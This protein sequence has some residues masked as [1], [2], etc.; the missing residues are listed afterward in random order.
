MPVPVQSQNQQPQPDYPGQS[1]DREQANTNGV[2]AAPTASLQESSLIH[3]NANSETE[4]EQPPNQPKNNYNFQNSGVSSF[5][6]MGE[7]PNQ[8]H[9]YPRSAGQG[10]GYNSSGNDQTES[11]QQP[12]HPGQ[13]VGLEPVTTAEFSTAPLSTTQE[14]SLTYNNPNT[15]IPSEQTESQQKQNYNSK[16]QEKLLSASW[17]NNQIKTMRTHAIRT[18]Q[19]S[20]GYSTAGNDRTGNDMFIPVP[21]SSPNQELM[22]SD[23]SA[24]FGQATITEVSIAPSSTNQEDSLMYNDPNTEK[25]SEQTES[26][27]KQNYNF[28]NSGDATFGF[29]GGQPNQH[30]AYPR[31]TNSSGYGYSTAGND[32]TRSDM[33]IPVPESSQTQESMNSDQSIAFGPA[34]ITEVSTAP[35]STTQENSLTYND[36]NTEMPSEQNKN[37]QKRNYN[38]Q[39]PGFATFGFMVEG[40]NQHH[41]YPRDANS[42]GQ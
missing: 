30:H 8:H 19:A 17:E 4:S 6:F 15:E 39:N 36:P 5:G 27:Q 29:M 11:L 37:Q 41:A 32:R 34:T 10:F 26:Q 31:N 16:I 38:F 40:P 24:A 28:Q 33:F 25:P 14:N 22:N 3:S 20:Y 21:E 12:K 9:A 35:S 18:V 2:S 1:V 23:Q 7:Q 42:S 13:S